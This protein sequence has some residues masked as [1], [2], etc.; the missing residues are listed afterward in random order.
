MKVKS[1]FL[2]RAFSLTHFSAIII[3]AIFTL[4]S[5]ALADDGDNKHKLHAAPYS[6]AHA[7][8]HGDMLEVVRLLGDIAPNAAESNGWTPLMWAA[9]NG[10]SE[11]AKMLMVSGAFPNAVNKYGYTALHIAAGMRN[12]EIVRVLLEAGANPDLENKFG[13]TS[14]DIIEDEDA[15]ELVFNE[16]N[17]EWTAENIITLL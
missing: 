11:I 1:K 6:L 4:T 2:V 9:R 14:W 17:K 12:V 7:A 13:M 5:D 3:A 8:S 16:H 15:M 10:H